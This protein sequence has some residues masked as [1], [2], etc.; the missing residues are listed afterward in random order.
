MRFVRSYRLLKGEFMKYFRMVLVISLALFAGL[1]FAQTAAP[2]VAPSPSPAGPTGLLAFWQAYQAPIVGFLVALFDL[3]FALKP[4]WAS[5][6]V[7]HWV[8]V[9]LKV[10]QGETPKA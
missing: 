8:L 9:Q 5:N 2:V 3:V 4:Q 1:A 6:G 10:V 7:L